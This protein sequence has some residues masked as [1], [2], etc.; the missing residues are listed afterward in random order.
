MHL[1]QVVDFS[2]LYQACPR[3]HPSGE[4]ERILIGE[5]FKGIARVAER[6]RITSGP[7]EFV[8]ATDNLLQTIQAWSSVKSVGGVDWFLELSLNR[9]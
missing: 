3:V 1:F 2:E 4:Y 9:S 5:A 8:T 6:L 7:V